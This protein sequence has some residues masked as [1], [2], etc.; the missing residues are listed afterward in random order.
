VLS[1]ITNNLD[2]PKYQKVNTAHP[3][4]ATLTPSALRILSLVG[5]K[6]ND[7]IYILKKADGTSIPN[8]APLVITMGVI[9]KFLDEN[10]YLLAK[11]KRQQKVRMFSYAYLAQ[12]YF[13]TKLSFR[14]MLYVKI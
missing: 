8:P 6:R 1:N 2:E 13:I 10:R 11:I 12:P 9:D 14:M 5:F 3:K 4:L 7:K